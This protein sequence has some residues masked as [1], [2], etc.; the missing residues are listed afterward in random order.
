MIVIIRSWEGYLLRHMII[1]LDISK[2]LHL[3]ILKI[4]LMP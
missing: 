1:L 3:Q 4:R 2:N